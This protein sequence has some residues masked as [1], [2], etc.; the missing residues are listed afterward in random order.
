MNPHP[1]TRSVLM[2][3]LMALGLAGGGGCHYETAQPAPVHEVALFGTLYVGEAIDPNNAIH[4]S[5]TEPVNQY[6][7]PANAAIDDA[8]VTIWEDGSA[9]VDTLF[10]VPLRPGFYAQPDLTIDSLTT[11]HLRASVDAA[12][13]LTATTTTPRPFHVLHGPPEIPAFVVHA[14]IAQRFPLV[15]QCADPDQIFL[16]DDY[17]VEDYNNARYVFSIGAGNTPSNYQEY[18]GDNGEP[19]HIF[20]YGRVRNLAQTPDGYTIPFYGDL[21]AFYGRYTVGLYSIDGNYYSYLYRD[22][23]ELH[24][25]IH[26]GIGCF[27]SASRK[28]YHV[29]TV[30]SD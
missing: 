18:G 27:S 17:C 29:N 26:G 6:Y 23:P 20:A 9:R 22:H 14:E 8:L 28:V 16:I 15:F 2:I 3:G 25:G 12:T 5:W 7:S 21:M 1:V 19:R 10:P 30:E 4:L 11:Y 24:G 13:V